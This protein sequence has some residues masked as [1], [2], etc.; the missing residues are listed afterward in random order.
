MD[1]GRAKTEAEAAAAEAETEKRRAA[2]EAAARAKGLEKQARMKAELEEQLRRAEEAEKQRKE[3]EAAGAG[4]RHD[5]AVALMVRATMIEAIKFAMLLQPMLETEE[6]LRAR[7]DFGRGVQRFD[8]IHVKRSPL[9]DAGLEATKAHT[10][11]KQGGIEFRLESPQ[12]RPD[13]VRWM[14][15][16]RA[17]PAPAPAPAPAWKGPQPDLY[18]SREDN[19][20]QGYTGSKWVRGTTYAEAAGAG[21]VNSAQVLTRLAQAEKN[22]EQLLGAKVRELSLESEL[23]RVEKERCGLAEELKAATKQ[24]QELQAETQGY[25][26]EVTSLREHMGIKNEQITKLEGMK[27][28]WMSRSYAECLLDTPPPKRFDFSSPA[29]VSTPMSPGSAEQNEHETPVKVPLGK[30][31]PSPK[32]AAAALSPSQ[33]R[34]AH[35]ADLVAALP[36]PAWL[37]SPGGQV[38]IGWTGPRPE[39][40]TEKTQR[41]TK[42][43]NAAMRAARLEGQ[44]LES[45]AVALQGKRPPPTP[46]P[47]SK[48]TLSQEGPSKAAAIAEDSSE[49]AE[50]A[51]GGDANQ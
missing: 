41:Q 35:I 40:T 50:S 11:C 14:E 24:I 8:F 48:A 9:V 21:N 38:P 12:R 30:P 51:P 19:V 31:Q 5:V 1:K 20:G 15:G 16:P 32:Q 6:T 36:V 47:A 29:A 18:E 45:L 10:W 46:S 43:E 26:A 39:A 25:R 34:N 4:R 49:T 44:S 28:D 22:I 13:G 3:Q 7:P 33:Q 17:A 27:Q 23:A 42:E 37:L 2:E